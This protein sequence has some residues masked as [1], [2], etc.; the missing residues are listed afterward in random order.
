MNVAT[1]TM[2]PQEARERLRHYRTGIHRKADAE[3]ERAAV[4]YEQLAE[5]TPL[6][7]LSQAIQDAPFDAKGRPLLAVARADRRQVRVTFESGRAFYDTLSPNYS[8]WR[9]RSLRTARERFPDLS[10][11]ITL[12]RDITAA[13]TGFALV[14]MVP[15]NVLGRRALNEHFILW[16][17][18]MWADSRIGATPDIDPYLLQRVA[19]DLFAVVGEW[20]LTDVERA[21]MRDRARA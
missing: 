10:L 8:T 13:S 2:D 5:G 1:I 15:P 16:D 18:Q 6:I 9:T 3:W 11:P 4:A 14:P 7:V 21:V 20:D 19:D 17:V 12:N